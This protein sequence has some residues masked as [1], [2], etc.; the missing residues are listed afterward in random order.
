MMLETMNLLLP[1][2][3]LSHTHHDINTFLG[4]SCVGGNVRGGS[5]ANAIMIV[6]GT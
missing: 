6:G 1:C 2:R 3:S 5:C 4:S